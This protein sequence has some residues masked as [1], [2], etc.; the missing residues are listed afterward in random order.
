[1]APIS[2]MVN[3]FRDHHPMG[4]I[5]TELLRIEEGI[6]FVR[7][8]IIVNSTV[9]GTGLAGS[10]TVEEAEDA[11]LKRALTHAGFSQSGL[12][13]T[14]AAVSSPPWQSPSFPSYEDPL[15]PELGSPAFSTPVSMTGN[16]HRSAQWEV[17]S[18]AAPPPISPAA[19]MG[20]P[21][22]DPMDEEDLSDV[23]AQTDV[24]MKRVGWTSSEGRDYLLRAFGKKSRQL[25]E[26]RELLQ[27]LQ[28]LQQQPTRSPSI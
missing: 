15:K 19:P 13:P 4:S 7:A 14:H 28:H 9:L 21:F 22:A 11:A 3:N 23:I 8:Q 27:F 20:S 18:P 1:M 12:S 2:A 5:L 17:S 25:L 6:H 24:E 26:P 10:P 16:G